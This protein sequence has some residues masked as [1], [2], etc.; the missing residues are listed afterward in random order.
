MPPDMRIGNGM[1]FFDQAV[2]MIPRISRQLLMNGVQKSPN[3][4][5]KTPAASMKPN[6]E[7]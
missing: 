3:Q 4:A 2:F 7:V 6:S 1:S 5:L